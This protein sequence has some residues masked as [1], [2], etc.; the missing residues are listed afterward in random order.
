ML[1]VAFGKKWPW[2]KSAWF[3]FQRVRSVQVKDEP[4]CLP[5]VHAPGSKPPAAL[6]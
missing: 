3:V 1:Y 5:L 2:S 4:F 6:P